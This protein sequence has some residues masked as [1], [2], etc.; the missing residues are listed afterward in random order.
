MSNSN[1]NEAHFSRF[2]YIMVAA[3]AAIGLGNIWK[4]PYL[5]YG[6][7]GGAFVVVYIILCIVLGHPVVQA[8]EAIG[9]RGK[10]N[11]ASDY[12]V[13]SKKWRFAGIINIVCTFLIDMYYLVVSG[14]VLK[15]AVTYIV[16]GDFGADKQAYFDSYI[17]STWSPI[18]YSAILMAIIAFLLYFG[19]TNLVEKVTKVIMPLLALFLVIC[20]IWALFVC[21]DAMKGL[22]FYLLPDWSNFSMQTF[23]DACMQVMFSVGIGWGIFAT[24]GAS[25]KP[26]ANL[27]AD[28]WWVDICD[29][30]IALL[31][32]FVIIPTVVGSGTEMTGGASLVFVAMTSIFSSLPGGRIMG[33]FFFTAL[34]FAVA[35]TFFTIL[36]IPTKYV[37]ETAHISHRKA[38]VLTAAG[39]FAGSIL[40]S[41]AKG[42]LSWIKL[43]WPSFTGI[44]YY[45]IYDWLDCFSGYVLLPLGVLLTCFYVAKVWGFDEYEKELTNNGKNPKGKVTLYDK[46]SLTVICPILTLVVILHVFGVF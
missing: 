16:S 45:D 28:A 25:M 38:T 31:A 7:G 8:E 21:P 11:V 32:G 15:Y 9:R 33:I 23:A 5:A 46:L 17:S 26:D 2:G 1:N 27:K 44:A 24:L 40:C 19:I 22:K 18:I 43:P 41:L 30:A 36:E 42:A 20:G 6:D 10:A 12:E 3:G 34:I 29:T 39:I 13:G 37:E 4:F 35:S 14:W